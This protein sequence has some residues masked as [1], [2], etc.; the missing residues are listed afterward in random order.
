LPVRANYP[1]T[2]GVKVGAKGS[3][4]AQRIN[5]LSAR[6]VKTICTKGRHA[7]GG[8]LYLIVDKNIAKRWAF[9]YRDR[10]THKL[11]EMGLGGVAAVPLAKAREKAAEART[12][13]S[14]GRDPL[15]ARRASESDDAEHGRSFGAV[16]DAL[17]KS[18]EPSWK[19]PKHRAQ[20]KMT[21]GVY[22]SPLRDLP[23]DQITTEDV[24]ADHSAPGLDK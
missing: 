21:L 7:D 22:C 5:R 23:I 11:R 9:L 18:M 13:L 14:A 1:N 20:W 16:A 24:L 2:V 19:N 8:G 6:T 17:I 4:M 10:R 15:A 12:H 3:E